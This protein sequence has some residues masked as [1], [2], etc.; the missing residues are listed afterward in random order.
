MQS[1][2]KIASAIDSNVSTI[3]INKRMHYWSFAIDNGNK[4]HI[5]IL[6]RLLLATIFTV[7]SNLSWRNVEA[8]NIGRQIIHTSKVFVVKNFGR[9]N[10]PGEMI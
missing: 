5:F 1:K 8:K 10:S 2:I 3:F 7:A 9:E 4:Y 6:L